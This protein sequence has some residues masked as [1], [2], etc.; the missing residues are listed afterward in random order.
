[1]WASTDYDGDVSKA[2]WTKL[3]Y[4]PEASPTN[5]WDFYAAKTVGLPE[6]LLNKEKVY[7]AYRYQCS[8][9]RA[10][11]WELKE[12]SIKEGTAPIDDD[13]QPGTPAEE[14]TIGEFLSKADPNTTYRLTGTVKNISNTLYGNFD[15]VDETGSVYIYGLLDKDGNAQK[16][17]S[18]G[19]KEGDTVTLEGK[20]KDYNGKAEIANAQY[21]SHV[22][23]GDGPGPSTPAEQITI[24]DFLSKADPNTTYRLAGKVS[25]ITNTQYGNFDLVDATGSIYIYGLLDKDGNAKNFES[26]GIKEGDEITLEGKYTTY[27]GNPQIKNAQ[28]ISGGSGSGGGD[29]PGTV[30][31]GE[32]ITLSF[33]DNVFGI[34]TEKQTAAKTYTYEGYSITLTPAGEGNSFY[35]NSKDK[36][37]ILGKQDATLE[38]NGFDFAV[39]AIEITGREAASASIVQNIFVGETAVSTQTTGAK[40][41]N[42]YN[43]ASDYQAAGTHYTL[44]VLSNHNTQITEVKVY[45]AQ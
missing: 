36:Y 34:D 42:V 22:S 7:I 24:A 4:K 31:S 8:N 6:A 37:V 17:E 19:I 35:Y 10:S 38:F 5:T 15:L 29:D 11:T 1:M 13:P 30:P 32:Y 12:F 44:K 27:N 25:N 2:T 3:N 18:I 40:G 9:E 26:L 33:T 21:I 14:I 16:F 45:K 43:I 39:S 20:Y 28:Y 23:S 41:T